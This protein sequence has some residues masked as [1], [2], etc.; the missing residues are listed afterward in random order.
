MEDGPIIPRFLP[1]NTACFLGCMRACMS[2]WRMILLSGFT[3]EHPNS[4]LSFIF[5]FITVIH[6]SSPLNAVHIF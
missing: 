5:W 3:L 2:W 1:L 6:D 4:R